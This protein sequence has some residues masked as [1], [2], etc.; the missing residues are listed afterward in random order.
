[1]KRHLFIKANFKPRKNILIIFFSIFFISIF[2][3]CNRRDKNDTNS[4]S[5]PSVINPDPQVQQPLGPTPGDSIVVGSIGDAGKLIPMLASD[6]ASGEI[7]GLIFNGLVKYDKDI[8]IVGDLAESWDISEDGLVITFHLKK[9]VKWQDGQEFTADDVYFTF[10]KI[11]DPKTASPYSGDFEKVE[12]VEI[13][14]KYTFKVTYSEPFAPGLISWRMGIIPRHILEGQDLNES[15]FNRNPI[16]TGPYRLKG[17]ITGQ[18]IVLEAFD[19]Y[20][21]GRPYIDRYIY[22]IIPDN[23]TMFLE[24]RAEGIDYMGLNPLQYERQTNGKFFK[25]H[26]VK[27]QY[28]SFGYTYLGYNLQDVRFKDKKIRQAITYAIN[29]DDIIKGVL[30]GLGKICTGPF[31]PDSWAYNP[32]VKNYEYNLEKAKKLLAES[33]WQDRDKDGWLDKDGQ[34]FEF[35]ILTNDGN[36]QREKTA[37]IIQQNLKQVGIKVKINILE[38]QALLHEFID[39]KRFETIVLGWSLGRE[40]DSYDIWHSSKTREGELNFISYNNSEVDELLVAGRKTFD[41]EERK[42]IYYKIHSI[43]AEDQPY[44]FLY[45]PDALPIIHKRFKGVEKAPIGIMHNFIEWYVPKQE[46]KYITK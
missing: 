2:S 16:G 27:Y 28:P 26:F 37:E 9:G 40:P 44:T 39:K 21:E 23:A 17:W 11:K 10:Q 29:R 12:K 18:K 33:G 8:K 22:R 36:D 38:W 5:S 20:F 34:I 42:K 35:T 6:S 43:L 4:Q 31:S 32:E 19:E 13:I 46:Q 30:L 14:D 25:D 1:M 41:Q 45:V 3:N 24:L 15:G 7:S